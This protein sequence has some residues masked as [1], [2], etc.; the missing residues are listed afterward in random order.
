MPGVNEERGKQVKEKRVEPIELFYDLIYVYAM[1]RLTLLVEEPVGGVIPLSRLASYVVVCLIILQSWLYLTNYVN[2]YGSWTWY[3]YV[4]TAVNMMA[5]VYMTNTISAEWGDMSLAFNLA[6]LAMLLCVAAMYF[7]QTRVKTQ[8]A[9]AAHN[10]LEILAVD[11]LLYLAA[12]LL[13][14]FRP[15]PLVIW[16]DVAAVLVGAFLPFFARGRFDISIISFPHLAERFEL[17]TI[18]TFGE[19]VVGMAGFFD[20]S[21]LSLRP[22]LVF[23]S[24]LALFG[25]YETQLRR[26]CDHH[27]TARAL[28]LMFSHYFIVISLNLAGVALRYMGNRSAD[29]GFASVLMAG[30]LW[31]Y[32]ISILSDAA[33]Y[34]EGVSLGS[35][36]IAASLA[37]L[38]VGT[39][40]LLALGLNDLLFLLGVLVAA[41]GNLAMLRCKAWA[42]TVG[43]D[44]ATSLRRQ[45]K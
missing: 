22:A 25:C 11:C 10:S 5:T 12:A 35:T 7:I 14:A 34:H 27:R 3:E 39:V 26:L 36:D 9:S 16:V 15:G 45:S 20:V 37:A 1:S 21:G 18:V 42:R 30:S 23:S 38:A 44:T 24:I 6:M 43:S 41:G 32:F 19:A 33:Y 13:A 17:L 40:V 2:R 29:R 4:L 8:D 28:L 31:L